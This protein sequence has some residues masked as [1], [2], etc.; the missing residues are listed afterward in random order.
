MSAHECVAYASVCEWVVSIWGC[1]LCVYE[2]VVT[3]SCVYVRCVCE[4]VDVFVIF[5]PGPD[6]LGRKAGHGRLR[7]ETREG[8]VETG[9]ETLKTSV[10]EAIFFK[11]AFRESCPLASLAVA[12]S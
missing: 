6:A 12:E 7:R 8:G 11:E 2:C 5:E 1:V 9:A 10:S 4:C 3:M